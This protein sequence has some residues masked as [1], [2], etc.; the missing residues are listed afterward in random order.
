LVEPPGFGFAGA[1]VDRYAGGAKGSKPSSSNF[2]IGILG[3]GDNSGDAC[4]EESLGAGAGTA[5][6][7]AGFERDVSRGAAGFFTSGFERDNF[8]VVARVILVEALAD[9]VAGV[10]DD[11]TYGGIRAC[12]ADAFARECEGTLHEA[13]VVVVHW[14]EAVAARSEVNFIFL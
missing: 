11:A 13:D 12:E 6:E 14:M 9:D 4:V 5:G 2:G 3:G 1:G 8:G 10:D 7:M